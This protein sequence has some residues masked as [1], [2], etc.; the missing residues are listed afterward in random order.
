MAT[1][2]VS[3]RSNRLYEVEKKCTQYQEKYRQLEQE[4]DIAEQV[5]KIESE[6]NVAVPVE[7]VALRELFG[8]SRKPSPGGKQLA[9]Y[10]YVSSRI[11]KVRRRLREV[12]FAVPDVEQ[13]KVLIMARR[14]PRRLVCDV[15]QNELNAVRHQLQT[16]KHTAQGKPWMIGAAVSIGMVLLGG[17]LAGLY[18]ALAGAVGGFFVGKWLVDDSHKKLMRKLKLVQQDADSLA[19][20]LQVC[21]RAPDWFSEAEENS[22]ERDLFEV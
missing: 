4:L 22:G 16:A 14:M 19:N 17:A 1:P 6:G 9:S 3:V 11:G 21:R 10:D 5:T 7:L 20:L 13:R 18:G 8:T 15:L 12:Y 2:E